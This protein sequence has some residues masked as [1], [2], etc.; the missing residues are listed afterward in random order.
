MLDQ[1]N[2]KAQ[3]AKHLGMETLCRASQRGASAKHEQSMV[4]NMPSAWA[5]ILHIGAYFFLFLFT[6]ENTGLELFSEDLSSFHLNYSKVVF[7]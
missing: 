6:S 7:G 1:Q 3:F 2:P 5:Q 4:Q